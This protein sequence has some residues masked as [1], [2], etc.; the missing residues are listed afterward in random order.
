MVIRYQDLANQTPWSQ[1]NQQTFGE[2]VNINK[3][4]MGTN[5]PAGTYSYNVIGGGFGGN[6][7]ANVTG[8]SN[9]INN[10]GSFTKNYQQPSSLNYNDVKKAQDAAYYKNLDD[11]F[12]IKTYGSGNQSTMVLPNAA[13]MGATVVQPTTYGAQQVASGRMN[14]A[15]YTGGTGGLE[16][17]AFGNVP[18]SQTP[19]Q[20][21]I[22]GDYQSGNETRIRQGATSLKELGQ[23]GWN[24]ASWWND[25]YGTKGGDPTRRTGAGGAANISGDYGSPVG[26]AGRENLY[27]V[28]PDEV[29]RNW[30]Y[31]PERLGYY[32]VNSNRFMTS[33]RDARLAPN[34]QKE[35]WLYRQAA[36]S[37]PWDTGWE[38]LQDQDETYYTGKGINNQSFLE[39][40][41]GAQKGSF[42]ERAEDMGTLSQNWDR[43]Q[44]LQN[45]PDENLPPEWRLAKRLG[46][47]MINAMGKWTPQMNEAAGT[48]G[49]FLPNAMRAQGKSYDPM[50]WNMLASQGYTGRLSDPTVQ[51]AWKEAGLNPANFAQDMGMFGKAQNI[52][53]QAQ[54]MKDKADLSSGLGMALG[55]LGGPILSSLGITGL[56]ATIVKELVKFGLGQVGQK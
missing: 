23:Q 19:Y 15:G 49:Y 56:P 48:Q 42:Q 22:Y 35:R 41:Y 6:Q 17:T 34:Q 30:A 47:D 20:T 3:S 9:V 33:S 2:G 45:T 37:N 29:L 50:Y 28:L 1:G 36:S 32:D 52:R 12:G 51:A 27:N 53:K 7:Y 24:S 13:K 38:G 10:I 54:L 46:P 31:D 4:L 26:F 18:F 25:P 43:W 40:V 14:E 5:D 11:I 39:A 55:A 21:G 8:Q 44:V 16:Q